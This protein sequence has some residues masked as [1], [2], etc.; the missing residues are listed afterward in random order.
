MFNNTFF[1]EQP[2]ATASE[3]YILYIQVCKKGLILSKS[4]Y[5]HTS[6]FK[7]NWPLMWSTEHLFYKRLPVKTS[8]LQPGQPSAPVS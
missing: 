7:F 4:N 2:P 6:G 8:W 1:T 3:S 5:Y